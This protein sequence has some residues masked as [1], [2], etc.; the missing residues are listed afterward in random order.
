MLVFIAVIRG[1]L[2]WWRRRLKA[3]GTTDYMC[4]KLESYLASSRHASNKYVFN[5]NTMLNGK[6]KKQ[7]EKNGENGARFQRS[8]TSGISNKWTNGTDEQTVSASANE[9][10]ISQFPTIFFLLFL[11]FHFPRR[12]SREEKVPRWHHR[13]RRSCD[14]TRAPFRLVVST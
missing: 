2:V 1:S 7:F 4:S 11:I 10:I 12:I 9:F 3:N 8:R 5:L 13:R 6:N 14:M